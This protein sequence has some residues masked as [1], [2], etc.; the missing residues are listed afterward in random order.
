MVVECVGYIIKLVSIEVGE[1][2]GGVLCCGRRLHHTTMKV[3]TGRKAALNSIDEFNGL[4]KYK[5]RRLVKTCI[6]GSVV[7]SKVLLHTG[8]TSCGYTCWRNTLCTSY[9]GPCA[10]IISTFMSAKRDL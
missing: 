5:A 2:R 8:H 7:V 3:F 10:R 1:I 6:V 4:C 9:V